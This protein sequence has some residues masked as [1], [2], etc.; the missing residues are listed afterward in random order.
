MSSTIATEAKSSDPAYVTRF[1]DQLLIYSNRIE[2]SLKN[3]SIPHWNLK[4][5]LAYAEQTKKM[6]TYHSST[7]EGYRVT[8]EEIQA[9][10]DGRTL[11]TA[12]VMREEVERK[13]ALKGYLEAHQFILRTLAENLKT[14]QP[15]TELIIREVYA[16]L[17]SHTVDAGLLTKEQ[18]VR[19]RNDAVYIR[20]SRHIPPSYQKVNDLMRCLVEEVNKA[21]NEA[22]R[23]LL[24][25]YGFVTIHPYFDGNGR[26]A[27]LLMNYVLGLGGVPWM[28]IRIEDRDRYFQALEVAQCDEDIGPF[29]EFFLKY[30]NESHQ[31]KLQ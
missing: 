12:D 19:Y 6:D 14:R 29:T 3:V 8:Q 21:Q 4:K 26:V 15:I 1:R 10:L 2:A 9:L 22:V 24:L 5:L 16:H 28:T 27:R 7:L 11:L 23:A 31:F 30:L 25:H 20:S 17:L 18:L 13:M